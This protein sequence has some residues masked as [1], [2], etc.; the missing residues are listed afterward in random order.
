MSRPM[1]VMFIVYLAV[2]LVGLAYFFALGV[3]NR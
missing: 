2:V 1:R 3:T